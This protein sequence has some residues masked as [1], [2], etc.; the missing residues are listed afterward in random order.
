M[1]HAC[2]SIDAYDNLWGINMNTLMEHLIEENEKHL[3]FECLPDVRSNSPCQLGALISE[4][5]SQQIISAANLLVEVHHIRL[6][7]KS[8]DKMV[9]WRTS[10]RFME[11][12]QRKNAFTSIM[13]HNSLTHEHASL[14]EE[15]NY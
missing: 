5:F 9:G 14:H 7:H 1:C 2:S 10:K 15:W 3:K 12:V 8:I 6:D 11:R 13:F 4:S